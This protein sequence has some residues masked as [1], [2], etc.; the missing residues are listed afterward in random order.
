VTVLRDP[1]LVAE[2]PISRLYGTLLRLGKRRRISFVADLWRFERDN[3]PDAEVANDHI[4]SNPV[5]VS[6]RIAA[7]SSPT[8]AATRCCASRARA[9]SAS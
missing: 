9:A 5:D 1:T 2:E 3:N 7:S 6:R 4:D 8:P